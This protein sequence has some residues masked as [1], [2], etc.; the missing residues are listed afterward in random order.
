M[1]QE[2]HRYES[3][4][5]PNDLGVMTQVRHHSPPFNKLL[6]SPWAPSCDKIDSISSPS[7]RYASPQSCT[8]GE[9]PEIGSSGTDWR[10]G[11]TCS[12]KSLWT[13]TI[14]KW[15][16]W[17][18][19]LVTQWNLVCPPI[20]RKANLLTPVCDTG[21]CSV[22][23]CKAKQGVWVV[24]AQKEIFPKGN[25]SWIFIGRTDA[26]TEA[27]ILWPPDSKNWLTGKYPDAGKDWRQEEKGTPEHEIVGWHH[28]LDQREFEQAPGVGDGQGSLACCSPWGH[29]ELD[30]NE[31]LN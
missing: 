26:V 21:N 10:T 20:F 25:Q 12:K 16:P 17:T 1:C 30:T 27:P 13:M 22:Y 19:P 31:Q 6:I 7:P 15:V 23:Y 14:A 18:C 9:T 5:I 28:W 11:P 24:N 4:A 3:S 29:K 8:A 2:T